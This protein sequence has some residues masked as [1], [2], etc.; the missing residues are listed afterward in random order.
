MNN[1]LWK[2]FTKWGSGWELSAER[3]YK[4]KGTP[5]VYHLKMFGLYYPKDYEIISYGLDTL[6]K[7]A[8]KDGKKEMARF[9][10]EEK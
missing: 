1:K 9:K 6:L 3:E 5:L 10:K 4:K 7:R 2:E 8:I